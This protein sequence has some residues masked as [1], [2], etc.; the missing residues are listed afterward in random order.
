[1]NICEQC[2]ETWVAHDIFDQSFRHNDDIELVPVQERDTAYRTDGQEIAMDKLRTQDVSITYT[3]ALYPFQRKDRVRG[4]GDG[5]VDA[6]HR[7]VPIGLRGVRA[8]NCPWRCDGAGVVRRRA[9]L[10]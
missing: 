9:R 6:E 2:G 10:R 5:K 7:G 1:M 8:R 3:L 4:G